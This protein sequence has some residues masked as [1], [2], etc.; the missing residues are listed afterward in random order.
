MGPGKAWGVYGSNRRTHALRRSTALPTHSKGWYE[1]PKSPVGDEM[2]QAVEPEAL[3]ETGTGSRRSQRRTHRLREGSLGAAGPQKVTILS[4]ER[5]RAGSSWAGSCWS[6]GW[7]RLCS[8]TPRTPP[9]AP[10]L[11][12]SPAQRGCRRPFTRSRPARSPRS[13]PGLLGKPAFSVGF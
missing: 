12:R 9:A 13:P 8:Q 7:G 5:R 11:G 2:T 1:S 10:G 6:V 3:Q 4:G